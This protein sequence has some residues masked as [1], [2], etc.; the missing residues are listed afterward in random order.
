MTD[1]RAEGRRCVETGAARRLSLAPAR[2]STASGSVDEPKEL[3]H[4][5]GF[6]V[7]ATFRKAISAAARPAPTTCCSRRSRRSCATARSPTSR[8]TTPD[9]IAAGNI[10]CITQIATGHRTPILHTVELLDWATG[11]PKPKV[12]DG[13][14]RPVSAMPTAEASS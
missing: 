7:D 12:L 8:A 1:A 14:Q 11:G 5:A 3:L 6:D 13:L 10:G 9:L 2:C 4:A